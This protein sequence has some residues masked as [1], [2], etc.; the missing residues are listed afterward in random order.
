MRVVEYCDMLHLYV[1]ELGCAVFPAHRMFISVNNLLQI[2]GVRSK[3]IFPVMCSSVL[4]VL[5]LYV[6][7]G[8]SVCMETGK[9]QGT[10]RSN[11]CNWV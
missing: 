5:T 2:C 6:S 4:A 3:S 11:C 9:F 10:I 1:C 8:S 7:S